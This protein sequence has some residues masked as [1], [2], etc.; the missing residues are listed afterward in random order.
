MVQILSAHAC[1]GPLAIKWAGHTYLCVS[2]TQDCGLGI[3][4]CICVMPA[5]VY[6]KLTE[7]CLRLCCYAMIKP[8]ANAHFDCRSSQGHHLP[9]P[10]YFGLPFSLLLTCRYIVRPPAA[11]VFKPSSHSLS[12]VQLGYSRISYR[13]P[14]TEQTPSNILTVFAAGSDEPAHCIPK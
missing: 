3:G 2:G 8:W 12:F 4:T 11:S 10:S 13:S 14:R 6:S 7:T 1:S 9:Q 5:A